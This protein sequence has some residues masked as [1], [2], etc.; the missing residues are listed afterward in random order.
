MEALKDEFKF[1]HYLL[2][3][4]GYTARVNGTTVEVTWDFIKYRGEAVYTVLEVQR[5]LAEGIW[6]EC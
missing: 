2:P 1:V 6:L 5:Y 3:N 4:E